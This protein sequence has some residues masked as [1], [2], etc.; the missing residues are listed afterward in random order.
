[1]PPP[2]DPALTEP[3]APPSPPPVVLAL[4][5][6]ADPEPPEPM[7]A[8]QTPPE[9]AVPSGLTSP[10]LHAPVAGSQAPSSRHSSVEGHLTGSAPRHAP[11]LHV[12][13]CVQALPSSHAVPSGSCGF[14]QAPG[15]GLRRPALLH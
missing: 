12:S 7:P 3:D 1:M 11:A 10:A 14:E 6:V 8:L 13:A 15:A 5:L 2:T 9:Q 4:E